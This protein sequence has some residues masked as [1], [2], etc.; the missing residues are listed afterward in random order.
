MEAF[1]L[2]NTVLHICLHGADVHCDRRDLEHVIGTCHPAQCQHKCSYMH[3]A[4]HAFT[5]S[6]GHTGL[7]LRT[8]RSPRP[9]G[10]TNHH[11]L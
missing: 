11:D 6:V 5:G 8:Y 9:S 3:E 2:D 4:A 7:V 10:Y 1:D